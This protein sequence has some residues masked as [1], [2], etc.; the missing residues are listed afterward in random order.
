MK[1]YSGSLTREPFMFREMRL[2]A[3]LMKDGLDEKEIARRVYE[4]NLFQYPTEKG[5]RKSLAAVRRRLNCIRE[6][7]FLMDALADGQLTEAKQAALVALMGESRVVSE[8]LVGVV[9]EKYR[10]L[11]MT[12]TQKDIN[13]FFAGIQERDEGAGA[14]SEETVR[15][16][17][18]VLRSILRETGYMDAQDVRSE[19]LYPV[20]VSSE[21]EQ[22][23]KDAGCK[24]FLPAFNIME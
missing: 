22:A 1:K 19:T 7:G 21:F 20:F 4:E 2:V 16:M 5:I 24:E 12:I 15:R 3:G 23:L 8:F 17:K 6:S 9:G 14:W 11:D 10:M 13:L 18:I